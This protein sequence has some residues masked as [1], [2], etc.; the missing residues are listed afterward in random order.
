M[1]TGVAAV[2]R[3]R[4]WHTHDAPG[5]AF[6]SDAGEI[7]KPRTGGSELRTSSYSHHG[8]RYAVTNLFTLQGFDCNSLPN[9]LEYVDTRFLCAAACGS[10]LAGFIRRYSQSLCGIGPAKYS[11]CYTSR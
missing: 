4:V 5:I 11:G 10:R 3:W 1:R 8:D 6:S 7:A 2:R 9:V